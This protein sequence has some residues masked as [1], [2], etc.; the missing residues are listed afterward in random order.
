MGC[1]YEMIDVTVVLR[2]EYEERLAEAVEMLKGVGV[3]VRNANDDTSV[4]EGSIDSCRLGELEK[5]ECVEYV[6]KG[7]TYNVDF[8]PGDSRDRNGTSS[9]DSSNVWPPPNRRRSGKTYP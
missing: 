7:M 5:L 3:E 4:V 9:A 1:D 8:P 6:R 2:R